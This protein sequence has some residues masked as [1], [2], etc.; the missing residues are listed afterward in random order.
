MWWAIL[1][2]LIIGGTGDKTGAAAG[3]IAFLVIWYFV[4]KSDDAIKIIVNLQKK[5]NNLEAEKSDL[6]R[7]SGF[8]AREHDLDWW[9]DPNNL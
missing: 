8:K 9:K 6:E 4:S 1:W 5:I 7:R 3:F 2:G